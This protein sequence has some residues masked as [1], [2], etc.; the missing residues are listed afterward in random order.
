MNYVGPYGKF[1]HGLRLSAD[2]YDDAVAPAMRAHFPD[3]QYAAARI[4]PGSDVLGFDDARSTDHFWG[5]L[6][7]LFLREQ[8]YPRWAD[9]I[10]AMLS[11]ELPLEVLGS[12]QTFGRSKATRHTSAISVTCRRSHHLRSTTA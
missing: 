3:V 5:P 8:D 11:A 2:F 6:L 4:G 7:H 10:N 12:P 9:Q 1:V